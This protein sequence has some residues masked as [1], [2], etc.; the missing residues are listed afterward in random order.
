MMFPKGK[1]KGK[2]VCLP[3]INDGSE[4]V[5]DLCNC[6]IGNDHKISLVYK[7]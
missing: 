3:S 4:L 1:H 6:P 2:A 7:A 5:F